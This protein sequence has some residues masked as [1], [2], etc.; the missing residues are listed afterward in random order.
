M[1]KN[2]LEKI[3]KK[4][5]EDKLVEGKLGSTLKLKRKAGDYTLQ[6]FSSSYGVSISYLSKIE[7]DHMKPNVSYIGNILDK[8]E[9]N[10]EMFS[11]SLIMNDWYKKLILTITG[12]G[13]YYD[14]LIQYINQRNDYQAKFIEFT[15]NVYFN[16]KK[17]NE[18]LIDSLLFNVDQLK[19]IEVSIFV[20]SITKY[21]INQNEYFVAG[22][23]INQLENCYLVNDFLKL[24]Y[25]ELV[26]ELTIYQ[27]SFE[28]LKM[29]LDKL[30]KFYFK[31]DLFDKV[32]EVR[33]KYFKAQSYFLAPN[34]HAIKDL[35]L[36]E[37]QSYQCSLVLFN[38]FEKFLN[39]ENKKLLAQTLFDDIHNNTVKV[40]NSL[41]NIKDSVDP[42]K[43]LLK[44]YLEAK[45]ITNNY[46]QVLRKIFFAESGY[47]EHYYCVEF[48][49]YKLCEY[50]KDKQRYKECYVINQRLIELKQA[51]RLNLNISFN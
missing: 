33:K 43:Q 1:K 49:A 22:S 18:K 12:V 4:V 24:W 50:Y 5:N 13:S 7:N 3:T 29:S 45:Y 15:L 20:L 36:L 42:F 34:F 51:N 11:S 16:Y 9:I 10:E 19:P 31:F 28:K 38:D 44:I 26:F 32:V 2:I 23:V 14:E 40:K 47:N 27:S 6:E 21:Y 8:L 35:S 17:T 30:I 41:K 46:G 39:V 48:L 25:Y 37:T